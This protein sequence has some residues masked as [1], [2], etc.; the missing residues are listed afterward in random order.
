MIRDPGL[1]GG[2]QCA[3]SGGRVPAIVRAG[4]VHGWH[5]WDDGGRLHRD[6]QDDGI[7]L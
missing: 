3:D 5:C 2:R 6:R 4:S 1:R 7:T